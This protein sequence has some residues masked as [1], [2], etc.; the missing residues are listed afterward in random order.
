MQLRAMTK[1][2]GWGHASRQYEAL[3]R[4][5]IA[6]RRRDASDGTRWDPS[7]PLLADRPT[8]EDAP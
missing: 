5:A 4:M 7:L 2:M 1:P 6:R 8:P 3:Y